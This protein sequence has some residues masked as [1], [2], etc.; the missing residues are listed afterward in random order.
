MNATRTSAA[1]FALLAALAAGTVAWRRAHTPPV[2]AQTAQAAQTAKTAPVLAP[3]GAE[4]LPARRWK[5][6]ESF[7][8][9]VRAARKVEAASEGQAARVLFDATLDATLELTVVGRDAHAVQLRGQLGKP[10]FSKGSP[11]SQDIEAKLQAPFYFEAQP[12]GAFGAFSFPK[13]SPAEVVGLLRGIVQSFQLTAP[14]AALAVWQV[15]EQDSTGEYQATYT[16]QA[17]GVHKSK[18]AYLRARGVGGLV[19]LPGEYAVK[20][21]VDMAIDESGWPVSVHEVETLDVAMQKSPLRSTSR[22]MARRLHVEVKPALVAAVDRRDL[23]TEAQSDAEAFAR[24]RKNATQSLV[25]GRKYRDIAASLGAGESSARNDAMV[26]LS[27]LFR[28][29]PGAADE[30]RDDVLKGQLDDRSVTRTTAALGHAGTPEAQ[31]ALAAII[32]S[33][34]ADSSRAAHSLTA[35]GLSKNQLPENESA[36]RAAMKSP[37]DE[38]ASAATLALG[39]SIRVRN[40]EHAGDT[41]S[42]LQTLTDG[43]A[44][45][46]TIEQERLYLLALGNTG[47]PRALD[48]LEPYLASPEVELRIAATSAL[49]FIPGERAEKDLVASTADPV[50]LVRRAAVEA[51]PFRPVSLLLATLEQLLQTDPDASVRIAIITALHAKAGEDPSALD[52]IRW[53]E[54]HDPL[55]KVRAIATRYLTLGA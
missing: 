23:E 34:D 31:R 8:Y 6:G 51:A 2:I 44:Q 26:A 38:V 53:A 39:N 19:P 42:T 55:A 14:P 29:E 15:T 32:A 4:A 46:A 18:D 3:G 35:L 25:A 24:A 37:S 11:Q 21:S 40:D 13:G 10:R 41:A 20:S 36:L 52:A 54:Q 16:R 1:V 7:V 43:L 17:G 27:A 5:E 22:T 28:L 49:R 47:D 33:P 12:S 30:A 48:V 9:E 45:A 50:H